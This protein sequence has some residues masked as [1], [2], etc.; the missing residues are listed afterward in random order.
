MERHRPQPRTQEQ[1][2]KERWAKQV[3]TAQ[4]LANLAMQ[5]IDQALAEQG[6][7]YDEMH[8]IA[9]QNGGITEVE[10]DEQLRA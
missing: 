5:E 2:R 6:A 4:D 3:K 10:I 9:E 8:Q 7:W 1:V